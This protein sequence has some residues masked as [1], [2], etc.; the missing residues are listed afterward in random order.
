MTTQG[1]YL[2]RYHLCLAEVWADICC[3]VFSVYLFDYVHVSILFHFIMVCLCNFYFHEY[4]KKKRKKREQRFETVNCCI[5][6]TCFYQRKRINL[7]RGCF[8]NS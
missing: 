1:P 2:W 4:I 6:M 5:R 7:K 3:L 8:L